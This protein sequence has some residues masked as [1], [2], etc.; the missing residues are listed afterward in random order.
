MKKPASRIDMPSN[1]KNE[2]I[3][4]LNERLQDGIRRPHR[5][6]VTRGRVRVAV[7]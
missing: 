6:V 3:A 4:I 1:A 7:P 2:V 5:W